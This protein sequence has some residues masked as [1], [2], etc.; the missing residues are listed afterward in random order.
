MNIGKN[1]DTRN[2]QTRLGIVHRGQALDLIDG[3]LH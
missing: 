3:W 2:I 1:D